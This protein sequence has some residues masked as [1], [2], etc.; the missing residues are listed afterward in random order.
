MRKD[1]ARMDDSRRPQDVLEGISYTTDTV[2]ELLTGVTFPVDTAD[3][4]QH[5]EARNA[6]NPV[7]E[8]IRASGVSHFHSIEEVMDVVGGFAV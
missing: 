3:L 6:P 2:Q 7:V 4:T 1:E 5:L 8:G